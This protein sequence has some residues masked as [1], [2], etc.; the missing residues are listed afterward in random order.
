MANLCWSW[1]LVYRRARLAAALPCAGL[2]GSGA[3]GMSSASDSIGP[4]SSSSPSSVK[5][6]SSSS[7]SG[8]SSRSFCRA[9]GTC[10]Q[11]SQSLHMFAS[12]GLVPFA[13]D[14]GKRKK[15][16][17]CQSRAHSAHACCDWTCHYT[18]S[19]MLLITAADFCYLC[20]VAV[21]DSDIC[22]Q[23]PSVLAHVWNW[24]YC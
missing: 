6:L 19:R 1:L 21:P 7:S 20:W 23:Q 2:G 10:Q 3:D 22:V 13:S 16:T 14:W 15:L 24:T 5:S 18:R 12:H 4:S 9:C 17:Q 8:S 11:N